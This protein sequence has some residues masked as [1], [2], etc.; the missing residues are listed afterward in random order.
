MNTL[1]EISIIVPVYNV[2][3]YLSRCLDSILNQTF[4][5]FECI[6]VDDCSL[7]NSPAVCD[8]YARKDKRIRVIHNPQ[9]KG[10]SLS[11]QIGL[12]QAVGDYILF[13]DSDDWI[14]NKMIEEMYTKATNDN[15]DM[16]CCDFY[17]EHFNKIVSNHASDKTD[18]ITLI[19]KLL[20]LVIPPSLFSRIVKKSIYT[21]VSFPQA[22]FAEDWV[23]TL[24]LLY[25][26]NR[27]D[28][29]EKPYYH[30][31]YNPNSLCNGEKYAQRIIDY[32]NNYS[33]IFQFLDSK[34]DNT[35]LFEPELSNRINKIKIEFILGKHTRDVQKLFDLYP[36]SNQLIFNKESPLPIYHKILLFLATKRIV[37]PLNFLDFLLRTKKKVN[38]IRK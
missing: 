16:I 24:Q 18:K 26:T 3:P 2:E 25:F 13:V 1:S 38:S 5:A 31:C 28:Y 29:I 7:D 14:E 11:R 17:E 34:F 30:Y 22:S 12:K 33:A 10:S 9:N 35:S 20:A 23:I 32:F 6:L 36:R 19:K 8:E 21:S 37:F 4:T 15:L 27:I